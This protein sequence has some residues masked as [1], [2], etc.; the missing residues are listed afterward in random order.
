M[1]YN[2]HIIYLHN[3]NRKMVAIGEN[4]GQLISPNGTPQ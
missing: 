3:M 2:V 4:L 1:F